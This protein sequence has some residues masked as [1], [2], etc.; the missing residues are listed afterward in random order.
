MSLELFR[1]QF[2]ITIPGKIKHDTSYGSTYSDM[3]QIQNQLQLS[4]IDGDE[5]DRLYLYMYVYQGAFIVGREDVPFEMT[6]ESMLT[7]NDEG[8]EET[9]AY[10]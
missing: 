8:G 7:A 1:R 4:V 2:A 6:A 3:R 9:V 10:S 5:I